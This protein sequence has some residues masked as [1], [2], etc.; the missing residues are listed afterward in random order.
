M[1]YPRRYTSK[2]VSV[3]LIA[4]IFLPSLFG[5]G[6]PATQAASRPGISNIQVQ[7]SSLKTYEKF[8]VHFDVATDAS[9]PYFPYDPNPPTG[10]EPGIEVPVEALFLR[11]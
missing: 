5:E 8:E 1:G 7:S 2:I 10:V 3:A 4:S 9:N 11:L 6:I